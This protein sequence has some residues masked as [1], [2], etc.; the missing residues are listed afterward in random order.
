MSKG[1]VNQVIQKAIGDAAFR[2]QLQSDPG[3]A[4]AGFDLT[5]DER[6]A[7]TSGD[8]AGLTAL[9]VDQRMSKAFSVGGLAAMSKAQDP[10]GLAAASKAVSPDVTGLRSSAFIDEG[11][12][13]SS[14]AIIASDTSGGSV[15]ATNLRRIEGD[16]NTSA[17]VDAPQGASSD[18]NLRRIEGDLNVS[19]A[20]VT[21]AGSINASNLR[22]IEGDLNT[23]NAA[24]V[25][26]EVDHA[27]DSVTA[28]ETEGSSA[29][30]SA[31]DPGILT[32]DTSAFVTDAD[33]DPS[34][35][36]NT[37]TTDAGGNAITE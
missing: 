26:H 30:F 15:N 1:A 28:F 6:S 24:A 12:A 27:A 16:L 21:D 33:V 37:G 3:K 25:P 7:I 18:F 10:G 22:R 9:G 35:L 11:G 13:A 36:G 14:A 19:S 20:A 2:R 5:K 32:T 23:G 4:L 31:I 17:A 8:P 34:S 29:D